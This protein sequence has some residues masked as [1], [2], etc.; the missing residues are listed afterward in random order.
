MSP[1]II[2]FGFSMDPITAYVHYQRILNNYHPR[3]VKMP[4]SKQISLA[5]RPQRTWSFNQSCFPFNLFFISC[6]YLL[7]QNS[8]QDAYMCKKFY[9]VLDRSGGLR[10]VLVSS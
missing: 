10:I 3:V 9:G 1:L 2:R 5:G 8:V 6:S 7:F 4:V